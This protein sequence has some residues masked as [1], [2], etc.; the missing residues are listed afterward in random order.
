[1]RQVVRE[2][3]GFALGLVMSVAAGCATQNSFY[4]G[5]SHTE[6]APDKGPYD[7]IRRF[8]ANQDECQSCLFGTNGWFRVDV[9]PD[10]LPCMMRRG[11]CFPFTSE[12]TDYDFHGNV[13]GRRRF[14]VINKE[15]PEADWPYSGYRQTPLSRIGVLASKM[16]RGYS[17]DGFY[18]Q[19]TKSHLKVGVWVVDRK[20]R[21]MDKLLFGLPVMNDG[22]PSVP[23][24][25]DAE[26]EL[27]LGELTELK[28][29]TIDSTG[30]YTLKFLLRINGDEIPVEA[31]IHRYEKGPGLK[32]I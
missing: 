28:S 7:S 29:V 10:G 24:L 27:H 32:M 26:P 14:L 1:M 21:Q 6:G 22:L 31:R 20:Q 9:Y 3:Y 30:L 12:V 13:L 2:G 16:T 17:F 25:V 8:P 18:Y 4:E 19:D 5:R 23:V 11:E 15:P